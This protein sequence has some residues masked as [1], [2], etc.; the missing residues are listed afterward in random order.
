M[1]TN[2]RTGCLHTMGAHTTLTGVILSHPA[3]ELLTILTS[4]VRKP[5]VRQVKTL[6]HGHTAHKWQS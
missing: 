1:N 6:T 5:I 3:G 2:D 4:Q